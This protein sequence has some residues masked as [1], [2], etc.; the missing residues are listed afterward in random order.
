MLKIKEWLS[1]SDAQ[2]KSWVNSPNLNKIVTVTRLKDFQT[3]HISKCIEF[4]HGGTGIYLLGY[5][6]RF[7]SDN[8]H[9][10]ISF[11]LGQ[12]NFVIALEIN[13]IF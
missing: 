11:V 7:Y 1:R 2:F 9:V 12:E 5:I 3:F 13:D 6:D 8:I 10:L 4:F